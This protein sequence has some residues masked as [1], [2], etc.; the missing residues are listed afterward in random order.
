MEDKKAIIERSIKGNAGLAATARKEGDREGEAAYHE[1]INRLLDM[2]E[3]A[4]KE[5]Q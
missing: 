5:N 3:E 1:Q 4:A 2:R